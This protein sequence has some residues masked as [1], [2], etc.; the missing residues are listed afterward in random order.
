M[1]NESVVFEI[2]TDALQGLQGFVFYFHN[3]LQNLLGLSEISQWWMPKFSHKGVWIYHIIQLYV[4]TTKK[5]LRCFLLP[6]FKEIY[7]RILSFTLTITVLVTG[8]FTWWFW[9]RPQPYY[10]ETN[11]H[12]GEYPKLLWA[13]NQ[14]LQY[15][16]IVISQNFHCK[17]IFMLEILLFIYRNTLFLRGI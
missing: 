7:L 3:G 14:A 17:L 9:T 1:D 12:G 8:S 10:L 15:L 11:H 6:V 16:K 5:M 2:L 4:E 13:M